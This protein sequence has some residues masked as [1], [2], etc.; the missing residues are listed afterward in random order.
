MKAKLLINSTF[1]LIYFL[2]PFICANNQ[3]VHPPKPNEQNWV[4]VAANESTTD[5]VLAISLAYG[6]RLVSMN[7]Y[8]QFKIIYYYAIMNKYNYAGP[9]FLKPNPVNFTQLNQMIKENEQL[10]LIPTQLCGQESHIPSEVVFS[11]YWERVPGADFKVWWPGSSS[12]EFQK[13]NFEKEGYYLFNLCGYSIQNRAQYIGVWLKDSTK[14]T[15]YQAYY[16]LTLRDS[17]RKDKQLAIK[18]FI[19]TR[20]QCFNN[21]GTVLCSGIWEYRPKNTHS[22]EIGGDLKLMYNKLNLLGFIPRQISHFFNEQ[23]SSPIFVVLWSNFDSY[24]FSEPPEIW[25]KDEVIPMNVLD[26][27]LKLIKKNQ[28]DFMI[29]RVTRFMKEMDIPGLSLA[30]SKHERIKFAAGF[31]YSDLKRKIEVT[32]ESQFRIGSVSKPVTASAIILLIE[33]GKFCLEDKIFGRRG[34][35]FNDFS[36]TSKYGKYIEEVTLRNLLEHT[37]GGWSNL[38]NDVVFMDTN[39]NTRDFINMVLENYP[40]TV[41]PNTDWVYSNFGYLLLG[42]II[43]KYSGTNYE[44][45]VKENIWKKANVTDISIARPTVAERA[46]REVLYYMSGNSIGFNPYELPPPERIGAFGGWIASSSEMLKFMRIVDGFPQYKDIISAS[47]VKMMSEGTIVSNATY[48]LGWSINVMGFNGVS[49]DGR[50]PSSSAMLVM[51]RNGV[52]VALAVNKEYSDSSYFTIISFLLHHI[53]N[54]D[55]CECFNDTS[56]L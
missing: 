13:S 37:T 28:L 54:C 55:S 5:K 20:F 21:R 25:G 39:S 9:V 4:L 43:E 47:S 16:G 34:I 40:L 56:D 29:D 2:F 32:S 12:A 33:K 11:S 27:S 44:T 8:V 10:D 42:F 38:E 26:G 22:I 3:I 7:Y 35:L 6:G 15:P 36:K 46:P 23:Q 52:A 30:I 18:G 48:G 31:G 45:F 14:V 41:K 49:H 51:L 17:M 24:R 1:L 53:A 19:A 50:M